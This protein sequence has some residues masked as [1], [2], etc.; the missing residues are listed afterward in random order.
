M[1]DVD[2]QILEAR[3]ARNQLDPFRAYGAFVE[4]ERTITGEHVDIA[5]IL[6]T[7]R[8]CPFRCLMCD[9]WQNTTET[10]VP[11][12]A[13]P[14]Q[15][16]HALKKLPQARQI[17]LYNAGSFFDPGAIPMADW[18]AIA[19]IVESFDRVIVEAHPRYINERC[20]NFAEL[21]RGTLEVA[22]G[23]ETIDP[24]VLPRLNKQMTVHDFDQAVRQL[25]EHGIDSRAFILIR[26]P[27]QTEDEGLHWAKASIDHAFEAGVG[28]CTLIPTRA[29]NGIMDKLQREG[30]FS[31]PGLKSIYESFRHGLQTK[32]GRT[33]LD[34]WDMESWLSCSD[35]LQAWISKFESMNRSQE[36]EPPVTCHCGQ[37]S[38]GDL[39]ENQHGKA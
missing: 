23:L 26:A 15:I 20:F 39:T 12:G 18:Q 11:P 19:A 27:Y 5:T 4:S 25:R 24:E 8:E 21:I 31:P 2:R 32:R 13:I 30:E 38:L 3:G 36:I 34:L 1:H 29:G 33:F 28:T 22:I 10:T 16:R 7:N 17:K 37:M 14:E 6:I 35:C 9:L